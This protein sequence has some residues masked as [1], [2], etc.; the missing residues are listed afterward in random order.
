[1]AREPTRPRRDTREHGFARIERYWRPI[2]RSYDP[3]CAQ[4]TGDAAGDLFFDLH[5]VLINPLECPQGAA[6]GHHCTNPEA[7]APDLMVNQLTL[8]VDTRYS[9]YAKCN[10]GVNGTDGHGH[11]CE[12]DTY[13]C[14]C[15]DYHPITCNATL[16]R[17]NV[18]DFFYSSHHNSSC[19]LGRPASCYRDSVV[20]KLD[21]QRRPGWWYSSLA[22]GYCNGTSTD[23]TWRVASVDKIITKRCQDKFFFAFMEQKAPDCFAACGADA[24]NSS[25]PCWTSCFYE[26]AL[27]PDA[28]KPNGTVAGLPLDDLVGAWL[29]PFASEDPAKGGCPHVPTFSKRFA[30]WRSPDY[31]K[32]W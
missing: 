28:G 12:D 1:V 19:S 11:P 18:S 13:C 25:S 15:G 29:T 5:N 2:C 22:S 26:T 21:P 23:C 7:I 24:H 17:E 31:S 4:D 9:M 27:G 10:I 32:F 30:A 14:Y 20:K 8:E 16:G 3:R 6:S